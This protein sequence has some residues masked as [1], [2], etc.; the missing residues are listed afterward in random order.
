VGIVRHAREKAH[1]LV[2]D[3]LHD[4]PDVGNLV[5]D[6]LDGSHQASKLF[7]DSSAVRSPGVPEFFAQIKTA[8][9]RLLHLIQLENQHQVSGEIELIF[10]G[11]RF[12]VGI[13]NTNAE[14]VQALRGVAQVADDRG[15]EADV[16]GVNL[17]GRESGLSD[18]FDD[19]EAAGAGVEER[20][21]QPRDLTCDIAAGASRNHTE[22]DGVRSGS[23]RWT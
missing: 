7:P 14:L 16:G 3:P 18:G 20:V 6:A 5:V 12:Q 23:S 4:F 15:K 21:A 22:K 13:E 10:H 19:A 1:V 2:S 17:A 8:Q 9:V 11:A